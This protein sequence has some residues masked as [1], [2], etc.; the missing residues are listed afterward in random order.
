MP[1]SYGL[2]ELRE[3]I[4]VSPKYIF[5]YLLYLTRLAGSV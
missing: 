1:R 2:K 3:T 4:L 5:N